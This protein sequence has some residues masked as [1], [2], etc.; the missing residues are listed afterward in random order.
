MHVVLG[1]TGHIGSVLAQRLLDAGEPVTVVSRSA[2][3][4]RPWEQKGARAAV[5]DVHDGQA[6]R[7]VLRAGTRLYLLNPTADPASDTVAEE[8]QTLLSIVGA[9]QGSGVEKVV[10]Q[11]TYGAQPAPDAGDLGVLYEM[12]RA[13][14]G[15]RIPTSV[16][17]GAYYMSNWD[18][19]LE[20]ARASGEVHSFFPASFTLPM[21]APADIAELAARLLTEPVQSTGL[22]YVEGPQAYSAA[23][24]ADAFAAAL[25]KP[26]RVTEVPRAAW[27]ETFRALGFSQAAADAYAIMTGLTLDGCERPENPHRGKTTLRAY[28]DALVHRAS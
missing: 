14:E 26:V 25:G 18:G 22:H 7:A 1:A 12:E 20:S 5:L 15:L 17:R 10:A 11:S 27:R 21:V 24:V 2:D 9:L 19:A 28:V 8:R 16:I 13:L 4:A 6:L 23:D 3:K